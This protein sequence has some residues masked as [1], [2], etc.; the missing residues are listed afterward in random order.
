MLSRSE[1]TADLGANTNN[2]ADLEVA[3]SIAVN[4]SDSADDSVK[5]VSLGHNL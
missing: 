5:L 2:I 1:L 4:L 3:N